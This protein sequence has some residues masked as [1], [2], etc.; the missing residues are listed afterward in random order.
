MT[1]SERVKQVL[2]ENHCMAFTLY[3][4]YASTHNGETLRFPV[5]VTELEKR[6]DNGRVVLARYRYADNSTLEYRYNINTERYTLT[7]KASA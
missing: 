6:N 2:T 5:G 3:G 1:I 7:S 4:G